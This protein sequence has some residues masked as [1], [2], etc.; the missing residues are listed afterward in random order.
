MT[1]TT[2][3]DI[4]HNFLCYLS[5]CSTN[6]PV[7]LWPVLKTYYDHDDSRVI[8]K[9]E[10]SIT[11]DA[12]VVIY[13]HHMFIVEALLVKRQKTS[14]LLLQIYSTVTAWLIYDNK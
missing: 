4:G 14:W 1:K 10:T 13:D 12:R 2:S 8:D 11:D 5:R 9:L 7:S 3:P 6:P